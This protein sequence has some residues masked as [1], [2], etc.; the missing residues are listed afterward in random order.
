M[1][2][3]ALLPLV[4]HTV[5]T[6]V[7]RGVVTALEQVSGV[8]NVKHGRQ[9]QGYTLSDEQVRDTKHCAHRQA[10]NGNAGAATQTVIAQHLW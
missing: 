4:H 9:L 5:C 7:H 1:D 2:I 8:G 6:P 3:A 10:I